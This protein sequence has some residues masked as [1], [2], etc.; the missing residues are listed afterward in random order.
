MAHRSILGSLWGSLVGDALGVPV[1]FESREARRRD[2]VTGMRGFGSHSQPPG[3]WSDDGA[4]LLCSAESL[5]LCHGFDAQDMARRFVRWNRNGLWTATGDVF[6]IGHAT[7]QALGRAARGVDPAECGGREEYQNGN[8]S[9]MRILPLSLAVAKSGEESWID[10]GSA[11]THGHLRSKL[12]CRFHALFVG[13]YLNGGEVAPA[14]SEAQDRFGKLVA[15]TGETGVFARILAAG[16]QELP[17]SAIHSTG[18]VVDTLEASFW[19]LFNYDSFA[20]CVLAAVNLGDDTDTTGCVT[21][22]L[23]GLVHG[24]DAVPSDWLDAIPRHAELDS[25][26]QL[27][28]PLCP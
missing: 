3:T 9:L 22:G 5:M 15:E 14:F 10:I 17:E 1:E 6:D 19:C 28:L 25:L 23:A 16:F 2:P 13:A 8:G 7:S 27:F 18:Y 12:A 20:D 4:L 21:G 24:L 26:F 11:I